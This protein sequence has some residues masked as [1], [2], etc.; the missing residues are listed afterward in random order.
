MLGSLPRAASAGALLAGAMNRLRATSTSLSARRNRSASPPRAVDSVDL[1]LLQ[2][3]DAC[4]LADSSVM[5][6]DGTTIRV[7]ARKEKSG[8]VRCAGCRRWWEEGGTGDA[9]AWVQCSVC[10]RDWHVSCSCYSGEDTFVCDK[11]D[12]EGDSKRARTMP[13]T[14]VPTTTPFTDPARV[15]CPV[16][17]CPLGDSSCAEGWGSHRTMLPHLRQH[18]NGTLPGAVPPAY[19]RDHGL[20]VCELCNALLP[21]RHNGVC[22]KCRPAIRATIRPNPS[23]QPDL[24]AH[25]NIK[26]LPSLHEV[27]ATRITTC[28]YV[29]RAAR[30]TWCDALAGAFAAAVY[31]NTTAAWTE[32]LMLPKAVLCSAPRA[33]KAYRQQAATFTRLRCE[34]W[35]AGER[36][37]LWSDIPQRAR[38][39]TRGRA[40]DDD[41]FLRQRRQERATELARDGLDAKACS[42]L[43]SSGVLGVT[44]EVLDA[45]RA[46]HPSA[47]APDLTDLGPPSPEAVPELDV[48]AVRKAVLGFARGTAPGPSGL[49]AHYL[50]DALKFAGGDRM[51]EQLTALV[52]LL[53]RGEAPRDVAPFV[54]GA[55]LFPLAKKDGGVRPIASGETLRRLTASCWCTLFRDDARDLLAP[56]QLG[57]A[58]PL[59]AEAGVQTARQWCFRNLGA[60]RKDAVKVDSRNAFNTVHREEFLR[61]FRTHLP[62]LSA[63]AEWSYGAPSHLFLGG[64]DV[65]ASE[66]GGQQGDTLAPLAFP[67]ALH[68]ILPRVAAAGG[69][70]LELMFWFLDDGWISGDET[71]VARAFAELQRLAPEIGLELNLSKCEL[72]PAAGAASELDRS[73]FP[74]ALA[75]VRD[76]RFELLGAPIGSA[77][78]CDEHTRERVVKAQPLLDELTRLDDPQIALRL[79]RNCAS[80]GRLV[81][82]ARVADFGCHQ[83]ALA[84]FDARVRSSFEGFSGI[85]PSHGQWQRAVL[86]VRNG[87]L[88]LRRVS[89]HAAAAWV[90]SCSA[91]FALCAR[92]D[93]NHVWD[94]GAQ[95]G[96]ATAAALQ[97]LNTTLP[98]SARVDVSEPVPLRQ[99]VLSDR[100]E[101][102]IVGTMLEPSGGLDTRAQAHLRLLREPG[103]GGV[104]AVRDADTAQQA[105]PNSA[106]CSAQRERAARC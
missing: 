37:S 92:L 56:W 90:A 15:F 86:G 41:A 78:H 71:A 20:C 53:A 66:S 99:H 13:S 51:L 105:P 54:A 31:H 70:G 74:D 36:S 35:L 17:G 59:G 6:A 77:A 29:P 82:A 62:G 43:L 60:P 72:I 4:G 48:D 26:A 106:Y 81:Y 93:P 12:V 1:Q 79:L 65:L 85:C 9:T 3:A 94:G 98:A 58:V 63:W 10:A 84:D 61:A 47:A 73:L 52:T 102:V 42:A 18:C 30:A 7:T 5:A 100:L 96:T 45:L 8:G 89:E 101:D 50:T 11:C 75:C 68:Q 87:G 19:L 83:A 69:G 2:Q 95:T 27:Y 64:D 49:R 38:G 80:F 21:A 33:G 22:P 32:L 97:H 91:T 67:I 25:P 34:R 28:K 24:G 55:S 46:K 44:A 76:S 88:G 103:A 57:V 40:E 16:T 23:D 14:P 104:A 39:S